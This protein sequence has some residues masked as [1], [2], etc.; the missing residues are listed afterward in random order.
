MKTK[1]IL[2]HFDIICYYFGKKRI[3]RWYTH[4]FAQ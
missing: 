1:I 2:K 4:K 3:L